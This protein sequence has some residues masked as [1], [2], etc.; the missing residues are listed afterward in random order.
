MLTYMSDPNGSSQQNVFATHSA[1]SKADFTAISLYFL[2][3]FRQIQARS[4]VFQVAA[5]RRV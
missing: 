3:I 2:P 5:A 1:K 4:R